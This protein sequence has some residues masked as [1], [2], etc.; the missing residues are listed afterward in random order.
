VTIGMVPSRR[1]S[2][3]QQCRRRD[4]EVTHHNIFEGLT[5][6]NEDSR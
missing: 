5:K 1:G 3:R 2:I 4:R 6:I